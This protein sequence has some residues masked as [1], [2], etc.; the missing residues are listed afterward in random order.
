[1]RVAVGAQRPW[2][3]M[4]TTLPRALTCTN[5]V[6][7]LRLPGVLWQQTL[8]TLVGNIMVELGMTTRRTS[9]AKSPPRLRSVAAV[10]D[11]YDT[12]T[13]LGNGTS[14]DDEVAIVLTAGGGAVFVP[15][16]LRN[17]SP[18]QLELARTLQRT[19]IK[20]QL[21]MDQVEDLVGQLRDGGVSW[22]SIGWCVGTTGEASRRRWGMDHPRNSA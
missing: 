15:Q 19:V 21:L 9:R 13:S 5:V 8:P 4:R 7:K 20:R 18:K 11:Y 6:S 17:G 2:Y 3:Y 22:D 1:M 16:S 10:S 12:A 14:D